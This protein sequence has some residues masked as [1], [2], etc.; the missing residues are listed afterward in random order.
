MA[1]RLVMEPGE[2]PDLFQDELFSK[3]Q[4]WKLST[5]GLSEGDRFVGTGCVAFGE[6]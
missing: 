1:L 4:E 2:T 5:S 6:Q 3:S